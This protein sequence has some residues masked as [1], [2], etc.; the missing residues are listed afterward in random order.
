MRD[1]SPIP[2]DTIFGRLKVVAYN[3]S[4]TYVHSKGNPSTK[5]RYRCLCICGKDTVVYK[6]SLLRGKTRSCGCLKFEQRKDSKRKRNPVYDMWLNAK[7]RARKSGMEF[8]IE[9]DD[10]VVPTICPVFG[11]PLVRNKGSAGFN[12]PS[13]DRI[14]NTK[15]YTKDNIWVI[16]YK[17]NEIKNRYSLEELDAVVTAL[18]TRK[19]D[20]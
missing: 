10:L 2:T 4:I 16:S 15:G 18:K 7:T 3:D 5:H 9:L 13:V 1:S 6:E 8:D 17:A 19:H 14:D 12:S 20:V 11:F